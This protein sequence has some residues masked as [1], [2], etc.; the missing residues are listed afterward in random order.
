MPGPLRSRNFAIV[1]SG[2]RG[3]SRRMHE[4]DSPT[5]II[6]SRTPCSSFVSSWSIRIPYVP[7]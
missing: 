4:P 6:A 7:S 1:D 5:P 2:E 3:A